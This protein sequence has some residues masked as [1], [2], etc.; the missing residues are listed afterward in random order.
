M[1]CRA[2][3]VH[4]PRTL[5]MRFSVRTICAWLAIVRSGS[6]VRRAISTVSSSVLS[7]EASRVTWG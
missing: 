2:C 3:A 7:D 5:S 1:M 6:P 4:V